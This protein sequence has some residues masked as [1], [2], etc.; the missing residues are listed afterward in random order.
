MYLDLAAVRSL[1]GF[2]LVSVNQPTT[3]ETQS[4]VL[5]RVP[6]TPPVHLPQQTQLLLSREVQLIGRSDYRIMI[7]RRSFDQS[8]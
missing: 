7:N 3:P 1:A 5:Q 4:A 6:R 2:N 8:A